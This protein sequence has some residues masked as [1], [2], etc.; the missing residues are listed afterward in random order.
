MLARIKGWFGKKPEKVVAGVS[1]SEPYGY[2]P[3][4]PTVLLEGGARA[5][6]PETITSPSV[7]RDRFKVQ[8]IEDGVTYEAYSGDDGV[9]ALEAWEAY[10]SSD[11][12]GVF[13]FMDGATCR[14]SFA[15]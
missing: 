8:R 7:P 5:P 2:E 13:T 10:Q 11:K 12:L 1:L 15:R 14:G 3:H 9:E 4:G 6:I